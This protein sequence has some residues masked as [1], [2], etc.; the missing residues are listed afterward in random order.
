MNY[1]QEFIVDFARRTR[2]NL[3]FIEAVKQSDVAENRSEVRVFEVTQ[4]VN[5]LLGLLVFPKQRY[6]DQIPDD[7]YCVWVEKHGWPVCDIEWLR[8]EDTLRELIRRLRNGLC[9][10]RF[11]FAK[12]SDGQVG[13]LEV[14]DQKSDEGKAEF[15]VKLSINDLRA[16]AY[17]F[18]T[19]IESITGKPKTAD[20]PNIGFNS[21]ELS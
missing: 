17:R 15:R 8:T 19:L 6:W 12:G 18:S 4:L 11:K 10:D 7:L 5:S 16:I 20:S 1:D 2:A 13:G 21:E 9:H 3:D 14:S